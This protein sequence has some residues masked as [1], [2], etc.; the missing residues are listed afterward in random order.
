MRKS[1]ASASL[2]MLLGGISF[3]CRSDRPEEQV[4]KAFAGCVA[5]VE[6]GDATRAAEPLDEAFRG[7]EGMDRGAA[8][9]YLMALFRQGRVG[10][11]VL[12]NRIQVEGN[13]AMQEVDLV[14]TGRSGG[15][16]PEETSRRSFEL[17][18]RRSGGIWRLTGLQER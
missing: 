9:L 14:L 11:T 18:W 1:I 7:P 10:V 12:Q 16:L 4:R 5:A 17:R 13:G 8:R 6:A 15:L 2:A 3:A